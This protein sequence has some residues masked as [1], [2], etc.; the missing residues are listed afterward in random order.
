MRLEKARLEK[1]HSKANC[2]DNVIQIRNPYPKAGVTP[3]DGT[4]GGVAEVYAFEYRSA[5]EI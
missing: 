3:I 4:I 1:T 2:I 5:T